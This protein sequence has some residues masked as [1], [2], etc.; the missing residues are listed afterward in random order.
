MDFNE[1]QIEMME[2]KKQMSSQLCLSPNSAVKNDKD[3]SKTMANIKGTV[4]Q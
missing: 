2:N 1:K 4:A 3:V